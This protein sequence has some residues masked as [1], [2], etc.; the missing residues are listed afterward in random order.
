MHIL[1]AFELFECEIFGNL[2]AFTFKNKILF[3]S[4][5]TN[6]THRTEVTLNKNYTYSGSTYNTKLIGN[7]CKKSIEPV[8]IVPHIQNSTLVGSHVSRVEKMF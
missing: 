7:R 8:E 6:L 5:V 1:L 3:L 4:E 2:F